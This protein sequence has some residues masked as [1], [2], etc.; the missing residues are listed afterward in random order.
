M[1]LAF[2]AR[3]YPFCFPSQQ[4]EAAPVAFRGL[5]IVLCH[6]DEERFSAAR[7]QALGRSRNSISANSLSRKRS[8]VSPAALRSLG[9]PASDSH[10]CAGHCAFFGRLK[11][12]TKDIDSPRALLSIV[13]I[14]AGA[15]RLPLIHLLVA[16]DHQP[17]RPVA[18]R[19]ATYAD[20]Q[21]AVLILKHYFK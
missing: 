17:H 1:A 7:D 4:R 3:S 15:R 5:C 11:L 14:S 9:R 2:R 8:K 16:P 20:D 13:T 12:W 21:I 19:A 18:T 10:P 6:Q